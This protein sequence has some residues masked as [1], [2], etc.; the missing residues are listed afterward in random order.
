MKIVKRIT[1]VALF[2][3]LTVSIA[4]AQGI[5]QATNP[6]ELGLSIIRPKDGSFLPLEVK[7]QGDQ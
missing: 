4:G 3:I 1:L 5:P 7:G 6:E 2:L